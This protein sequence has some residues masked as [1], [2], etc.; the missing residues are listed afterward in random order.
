MRLNKNIIS[1]VMPA[2]SIIVVISIGFFFQ[3]M[4]AIGLGG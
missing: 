1:K 3:M 2:F 4:S